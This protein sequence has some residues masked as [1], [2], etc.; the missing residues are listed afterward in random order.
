MFTLC[1]LYRTALKIV[2]S[3]SGHYPP[4]PI[5]LELPT[6]NKWGKAKESGTQTVGLK[7]HCDF[8][9][10]AFSPI[11]SLEEYNCHVIRATYMAHG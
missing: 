3:D 7:L 9:L 2:L 8:N 4:M 1:F 10:S 5:L 6:H 11:T